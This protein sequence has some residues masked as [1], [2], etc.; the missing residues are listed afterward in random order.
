VALSRRGVLPVKNVATVRTFGSPAIF[1]EGATGSSPA[2]GPCST[3]A[4]PCQHRKGQCGVL[5]SVLLY[6]CC[7]TAVVLPEW[8]LPADMLTCTAEYSCGT[9]VGLCCCA[10]LAAL[11]SHWYQSVATSLPKCRCVCVCSVPQRV[12]HDVCVRERHVCV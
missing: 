9:A 7:C 2:A 10:V 5:A 8:W 12:C 11:P 6:C 1:C 3:C 4:L